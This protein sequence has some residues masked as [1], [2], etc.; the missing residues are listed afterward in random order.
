MG[1]WRGAVDV[2]L[3]GHGVH[4]MVTLPAGLAAATGL[5]GAAATF[6]VTI[7]LLGFTVLTAVFGVR[8]GR[9][10]A[11]S[12]SR[13]LGILVAVVV[14]AALTAALLFSAG[15]EIVRPSRVQGLLLPTLIYFV[16]AV[17]GSEWESARMPRARRDA[18]ARGV[19]DLLDRWPVAVRSGVAASVRGAILAVCGL[20]AVAAV[21]VA[22]A[23]VANY[24]TITSLYETLHAGALGGAAITVIEL[25]LLPNVIIW[26]V[27]WLVGPGF[28]VGVGSSV[29]PGA[30]VLGTLPGLPLVGALPHGS[31]A[32]GW[33]GVLVPVVV[34]AA[35]GWITA[36]RLP[37]ETTILGRTATGLGVGVL[38]GLAIG[39][40]AWLSAGAIGPGRLAQ[41][42]PDPLLTGAFA[43]LE[44]G[45]P[46]AVF[47]ALAGLRRLWAADAVSAA[48]V[49]SEGAS[50]SR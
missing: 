45:V 17:I 22:V 11:L 49:P 16:A 29:G 42:G 33:L 46:A 28:A 26:T 23:M 1:F 43:A 36:R 10:S 8:V 34:G 39:A 21:V 18:T 50:L 35:G 12:R 24:A 20:L 40:A 25:A 47:C 37:A 2:W 14:F 38:A 48:S 31:P 41:V 15:E 9:R 30:T 27:S 7:A 32:I 13:V 3:L 5:P 6:P 4:L 19:G 44:I